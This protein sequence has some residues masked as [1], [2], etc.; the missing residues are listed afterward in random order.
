MVPIH[1]SNTENKELLLGRI[2]SILLK[3]ALKRKLR[4]QVGAVL[5][6]DR[7]STVVSKTSD[8]TSDAHNIDLESEDMRKCP[9]EDIISTGGNS[10]CQSGSQPVKPSNYPATTPSIYAG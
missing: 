4:K 6:T 2:Y 3:R 8:S 9:D 5:A 1:V 10:E 7:P